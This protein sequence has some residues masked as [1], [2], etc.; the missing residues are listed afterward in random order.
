MTNERAYSNIEG[1]FRLA[2]ATDAEPVRR[3]LDHDDARLLHEILLRRTACSTA[4]Q[5]SS[6]GA[7]AERAQ[8][9]HA[10]R[11]TRQGASLKRAIEDAQATYAEIL[12]RAAG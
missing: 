1:V 4:L 10:A 7:P 12:R 9:G 2:E 11:I 6:D 3:R 8:P 5:L